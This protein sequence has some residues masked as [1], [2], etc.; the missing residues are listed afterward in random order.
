[1]RV[2]ESLV[3]CAVRAYL[4]RCGWLLVAGQFPGGTDDECH[5]L[6]VMDPNLCGDN[7]PDP[8]RHSE[9]KLVPDLFALRDGVLLVIEMKPTYSADD[10]AKLRELLTTRREHLDL[11]LATFARDRGMP[12]L[13]TPGNLIVIPGLAFG[14]RSRFTPDPEFCYFLV[15]SMDDVSTVPPTSPIGSSILQLFV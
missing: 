4:K 5:I 14:A 10:A 9:N 2:T 8:S 7:C 12:L 11:A 1:M 15:R 3:H 6:N 13:A